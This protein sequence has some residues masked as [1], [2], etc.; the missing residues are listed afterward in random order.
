[1]GGGAELERVEERM[2]RK[3]MEMRRSIVVQRMM[4][5]VRFGR[6]LS[7]YLKACICLYFK[8]SDM[9]MIDGDQ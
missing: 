4:D 1:M 2:R 9:I 3:L 5:F 7:R 8:Y 6:F